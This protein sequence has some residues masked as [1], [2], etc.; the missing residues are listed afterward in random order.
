MGNSDSDSYAR[1]S[2][3]SCRLVGQFI[4]HWAGV[5]SQLDNTMAAAL[6]LTSLQAAIVAVNI[7]VANKIHITAT[8]VELAG[9]DEKKIKHYKR[10]LNKLWDLNDDR[11]MLVHYMFGP[12]E[13]ETATNFIVTQAKGKLKF[14]DIVWTSEDFAKRYKHMRALDQKLG[15]LTKE[16]KKSPQPPPSFVQL[17]L[18]PPQQAAR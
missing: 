12:S 18:R 2:M 4:Q 15:E 5:E 8:A 3:R 11:N 9:L 7:P 6:G 16:L 14:P 10:H 13:D 1:A 17:R